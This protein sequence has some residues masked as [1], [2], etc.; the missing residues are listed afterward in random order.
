MVKSLCKNG[1]EGLNKNLL[2]SIYGIFN[3]YLSEFLDKMNLFTEVKSIIIK[4]TAKYHYPQYVFGKSISKEMLLMDKDNITCIVDAPCGNGEVAY[5]LSYSLKR[6][7]F[8]YDI[9]EECIKMASLHFSNPLT[10]FEKLDIRFMEIKHQ[11][12][13]VWCIVNSLFLFKDAG[14]ILQTAYKVL[15]DDGWLI[16]ILPNVE[17]KNYKNFC[18]LYK[19]ENVFTLRRHEF[20]HFFLKTGFKIIKE[21]GIVY[22]H[23]YGRKELKF[24]SVLSN[25]YLIFMNYIQSIFK[26]W[27][28]NYYLLVLKKK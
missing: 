19:N 14:N 8:A 21:K 27:A 2:F 15:K 3:L 10:V 11:Q 26:V 17:G 1:V 20:E 13:D 9:S 18:K 24:L 7:V 25:F 4:W 5:H 16:L 22:A 6:R 23:F 28:P 12:I